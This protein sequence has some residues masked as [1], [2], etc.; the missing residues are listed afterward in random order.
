ME[1]ADLLKRAQAVKEKAYVP[2]TGFKVGAVAVGGSGKKYDGCNIEIT[3]LTA[4]CCAERN[5]LYS[6]IA[7]G[8]THINKIVMISDL[9]GEWLVPCGVCRQ[10]LYEFG[11]CDIIITKNEEDG[12]ISTET[13]RLIEI[14]P[15]AYKKNISNSDCH[16]EASQC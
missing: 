14:L 13:V 4:S 16:V 9:K 6:A 5:A 7:G 3:G 10:A 2:Y 15:E 1:A 11:D 8:E 12:T